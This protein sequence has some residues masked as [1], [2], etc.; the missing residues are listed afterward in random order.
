MNEKHKKSPHPVR[1]WIFNIGLFMLALLLLQWWQSRPLASGPAPTLAAQLINGE[2]VD[3]K[4]YRGKPVLVH[5]WAEWCPICSA[6]Q[7]SIQSLSED[8]EVLSI[9]MQS[10]QAQTVRAFMQQENLSF[11]TIA[12]PLGEISGQW[13][14]RAVPVSFIID[15][16]GDI[17]FSEV[18]YTTEAGLRAR[19]WA[20]KK[21]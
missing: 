2:T 12:D 8:F 9:A 11:P 6:E 16:Q 19:L 20:A 4:N 18:G 1:R 14:V 13:G 10:G 21:W 17:R 7:D 3:L 15:G 5:F